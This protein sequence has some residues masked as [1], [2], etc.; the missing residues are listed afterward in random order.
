MTKLIA[1]IT[2]L[3]G[4]FFV[5]APAAQA[6]TPGCVTRGEYRRVHRPMTKKRVHRI[7]DHKG[8]FVDGGAGGYAR[9]YRTCTYRH[10]FTIEY[11]TWNPRRAKPRVHR[12]ANKSRWRPAS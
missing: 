7:F 8:F 9:S 4:S 11:S 5:A 3:V 1:V 6:D 2:L 10:A 12:M